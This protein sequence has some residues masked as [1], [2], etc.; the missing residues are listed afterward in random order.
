MHLLRAAVLAGVIPWIPAVPPAAPVPPVAPPCRAAALGAQLGLQGAT[1]SLAGGVSLRTKGAEPCSLRGR[2]QVR[3]LDGSDP[4]GVDLT[5]LAPQ[6]PEP[7]VPVPSLRALR[8]G[9]SAFVRI[10]WSNW[11][12]EPTPTTLGL[13]LPSGDEIDLALGKAAPRCDAPGSPSSLAVGPLE[14]RPAEPRPS[15]RLPLAA[16]IVEQERL[17]P[18]VIP[19]VHG[20]RGS[21]AVYH[22]ALTNTSSRPF[23]FG[24]ICPVYVEGTELDQPFERHVL[25]CRPVGTMR[26]NSR[27]VLEMRIL[28][29]R[30]L[31]P[32][33]HALTWQ[34]APASYLP[35]FAGGIIVVTG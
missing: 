9:E 13:R 11:C 21:T 10:W 31:R 2:L 22:V 16:S 8:P 6:R 35:P 24:A 3:F 29:P 33:R 7:G 27:V 18:K 20:R 14:P 5:T 30:D 12:G 34:L 4:A 19:T 15:T 28:V 23:R 17:G 32:G 25:N 1:G 26:P